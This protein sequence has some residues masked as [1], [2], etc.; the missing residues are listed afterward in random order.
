[1]QESADSVLPARALAAEIARAARDRHVSVGVAESL[2]SG[3][4]AA[5]LGAAPS[6]S[7]WF[8]GGVVAYAPEVKFDLLG[9]TRGPVNCASCAKELALGAGRVLG[10]DLAVA[11]TGVGGP[12]PD[13]GVPAGTVF[14]G[15]ARGGAVLEVAE[16]HLPGSPRD[17]LDATVSVCLRML[18]RSLADAST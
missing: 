4:L 9:V 5:A 10:A 8:R 3:H 16:L 11:A 1:M 18:L 7:E 6:A 13:D 2:T 12:G 15:V 14:V 17:V